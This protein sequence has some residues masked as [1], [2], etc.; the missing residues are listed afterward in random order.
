MSYKIILADSAINDLK[1][2]D[3]PTAKRIISKLTFFQSSPD[4]L[5]NAKSLQG[6]YKG[7][8]RFRIGDYRAIFSK[9]SKNRITI[10]LVIRVKHRKEVYE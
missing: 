9:D 4:P 7:L 3:A 1:K 5:A 6:K 2:I 10:L 8:Y